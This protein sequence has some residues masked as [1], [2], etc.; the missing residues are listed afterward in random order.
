MAASV[1][2]PSYRRHSSTPHGYTGALPLSLCCPGV[3]WTPLSPAA[4]GH[5]LTFAHVSLRSA[6]AC[7]SPSGPSACLAP[8]P[9]VVKR[10]VLGA[11]VV[12]EQRPPT[13]TAWQGP[14]SLPLHA[15]NHCCRSCRWRGTARSA[16][17][18]PPRR[19]TERPAAHPITPLHPQHPT[20]TCAPPSGPRVLVVV[21]HIGVY[22]HGQRPHALQFG[23]S[24]CLRK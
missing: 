4:Q 16:P 18:K 10:V 15:I 13:R 2:G 19:G 21:L 8:A 20:R 22:E 7:A 23:L 24:K 17:L 5:P 3:S 11:W 14:R 12:Y 9:A 1:S 6:V